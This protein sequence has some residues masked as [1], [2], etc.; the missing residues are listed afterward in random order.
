MACVLRGNEV[1]KSLTSPSKYLGQLIQYYKVLWKLLQELIFRLLLWFL[2]A[3]NSFSVY[4]NNFLSS[5]QLEQSALLV[6][7]WNSRKWSWENLYS[8]SLL[9][10]TLPRKLILKLWIFLDTL[11][12]LSPWN[13]SLFC[14]NNSDRKLSYHLSRGETWLSDGKLTCFQEWIDKNE[15]HLLAEFMQRRFACSVKSTKLPFSSL[16]L[17][18]LVRLSSSQL[19]ARLSVK[20]RRKGG[21]DCVSAP[22]LFMVHLWRSQPSPA[23]SS[24]THLFINERDESVKSRH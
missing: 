18:L 21:G 7:N 8:K 13:T 17:R 10:G 19:W 6:P 14:F 11:L 3:N 1:V 15:T 12:W 23:L 4:V 16:L 2:A 22:V 5:I 20:Q 9:V 24:L